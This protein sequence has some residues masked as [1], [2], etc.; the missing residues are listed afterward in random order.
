MEEKGKN[1]ND[2]VI[3]LYIKR[4]LILNFVLYTI[5]IILNEMN[6]VLFSCTLLF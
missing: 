6:D 4:I 5:N 3:S 2:Y 1:T